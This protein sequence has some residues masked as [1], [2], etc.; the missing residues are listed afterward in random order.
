MRPKLPDG[1]VRTLEL[2]ELE[3]VM[4]R[5][6]VAT[7]YVIDHCPDNMQRSYLWHAWHRFNDGISWFDFFRTRR[8]AGGWQPPSLDD[9]V[10]YRVVGNIM[11]ADAKS[12]IQTLSE[13]DLGKLDFHLLVDHS[14]SMGDPSLRRSG[15][16]RLEE[17]AEDATAIAREAQKYDSDGITVIAFSTAVRVFDGV[18]AEKVQQ[19]FQEIKPRGST[20]LLD[21][22]KASLELASKSQKNV[23]TLIFTDGVPDDMDGVYKLINNAGKQYGR[24]KIGF[25]FVQVGENQ[26]AT[27]F[28]KKLNDNLSVDVVACATAAEAEG[29]SLGQLA[30]LGQNA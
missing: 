11:N 9:R 30:W 26:E 23:I 20:N 12:V 6:R 8:V 13:D 7:A 17:L 28:L 2:A 5:L 10:F 19:T 29:L 25:T 16:N 21:A 24:P 22:I 3:L 18:T 1:T 27:A 15:K 4:R 14:G